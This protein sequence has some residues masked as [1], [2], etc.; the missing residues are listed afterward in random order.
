MS[1]F[2]PKGS[3][4]RYPKGCQPKIFTTCLGVFMLLGPTFQ[5]RQEVL[6]CKMSGVGVRPDLVVVDIRSMRFGNG[7]LT[8]CL[9]VFT[10]GNIIMSVVDRDTPRNAAVSF[11]FATSDDSLPLIV[12]T[13]SITG[14]SGSTGTS[15]LVDINCSGLGLFNR[16]VIADYNMTTH[17]LGSLTVTNVRMLLVAADSLSVSLLIRTRGRSTTCRTLGGTCRLWVLRTDRR[18]SVG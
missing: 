15:P 4:I 7:D 13:V 10:S 18:S 12:G 14:L 11:Y 5:T 16:R 9:R 17:T 8:H 6:V 2:R 1:E 3:S